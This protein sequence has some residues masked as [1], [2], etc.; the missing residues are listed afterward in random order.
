V[1]PD[2]LDRFIE[3]EAKLAEAERAI[4]QYV[5]GDVE[6]SRQLSDMTRDRDAAIALNRMY[7]GDTDVLKAELGAARE[8]LA[9]LQQQQNGIGVDDLY[10]PPEPPSP[11][12]PR[13]GGSGNVSTLG[14]G[15]VLVDCP[16]CGGKGR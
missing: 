8:K 13:C 3:L 1:Q 10:P 5:Q 12:C 4:E 2:R 14:L 7:L 16:E 9:A 15:P 11:P 6:N